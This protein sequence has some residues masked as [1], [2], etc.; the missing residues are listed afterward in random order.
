MI[1]L[2]IDEQK[3]LK[4]IKVTPYMQKAI[5]LIED[6]VENYPSKDEKIAYMA[7]FDE[8]FRILNEAKT[9]VDIYLRKRKA[10]GEIKD[11]K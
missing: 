10:R 8:I 5:A 9:D 4:S 11:E 7:V 3:T 6:F 1:Q 2:N